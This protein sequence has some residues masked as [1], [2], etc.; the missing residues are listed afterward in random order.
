MIRSAVGCSTDTEEKC[1]IHSTK[2]QCE[3]NSRNPLDVLFSKVKDKKAKRGNERDAIDDK[4]CI[5]RQKLVISGLQLPTER[6][7]SFVA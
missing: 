4:E 1:N 6:P 3:S 7:F 2:N 5:E